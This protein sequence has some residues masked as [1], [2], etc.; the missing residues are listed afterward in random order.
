MTVSFLKLKGC[1]N[2]KYHCAHTIKDYARAKCGCADF[3]Y[4]CAHRKKAALRS[5]LFA[6]T[7]SVIALTKKRLRYGKMW[8]R[9]PQ[10]RLRVH[11]KD[12]ASVKFGCADFKYHCAH[13]KKAEQWQNSFENHKVSTLTGRYKMDVRNINIRRK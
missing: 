10:I 2:F 4:D 8:L 7:S 12:C 3:K 9:L 11:K 1:A 5:N 6:L 13:L